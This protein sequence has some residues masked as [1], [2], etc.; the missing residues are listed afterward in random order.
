ML[1]TKLSRRT[2]QVNQ[3]IKREL[4]KI[5]LKELDVS[6]EVLVTVTR[7][8]TFA[9]LSEAR[10]YIS[11]IPD[12]P[13]IIQILNNKIYLLQRQLNKRLKMRVVPKIKF[14]E[15]K[16]AAEAE[17]IEEILEEINKE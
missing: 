5:L 16:K 11:T 12:S 3:L 9:N 4:S 2:E 6:E 14:I 1:N 13:K 10:V 15:E 7:V 17:R 8:E